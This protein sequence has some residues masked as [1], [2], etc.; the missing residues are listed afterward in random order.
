DRQPYSWSYRLSRRLEVRVRYGGT[1]DVRASRKTQ[2]FAVALVTF[3]I[4]ILSSAL[5]I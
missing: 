2:P 5:R 4:D 1:V 3:V